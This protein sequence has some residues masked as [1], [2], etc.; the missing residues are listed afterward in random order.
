[1]HLYIYAM[2]CIFF[3]CFE[4]QDPIP[5]PSQTHHQVAW[6]PPKEPR[7]TASAVTSKWPTA[8]QP[9]SHR[10]HMQHLPA[11]A[12]SLRT[13][14]WIHEMAT[15]LMAFNGKSMVF[16]RF[17]MAFEG[18]ALRLLLGSWGLLKAVENNMKYRLKM[19]SPIYL[20]SVSRLSIP[21]APAFSLRSKDPMKLFHTFHVGYKAYYQYRIIAWL[22]T[23]ECLW[24]GWLKLLRT[25]H[26]SVAVTWTILPQ[27]W[28]WSKFS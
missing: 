2:I 18:F 19:M 20:Y 4:K 11:A 12:R 8:Q 1:M 16:A 21:H 14:K 26:Q 28:T 3:G 7:P 27:G 17:S 22:A 10:Q 6:L 24:L 23:F 9:K 13:I 5:E 25:W 15:P